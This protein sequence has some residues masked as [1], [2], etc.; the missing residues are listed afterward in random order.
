M[1]LAEKSDTLLLALNTLIAELRKCGNIHG[2]QIP[3]TF[4]SKT[5]FKRHTVL[6]F[7]T[8]GKRST[9]LNNLSTN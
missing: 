3:I 6:A 1:E 8:A 9:S 4:S 7:Q 5:I 2:T